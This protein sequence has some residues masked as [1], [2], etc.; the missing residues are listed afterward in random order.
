MFKTKTT[1]MKFTMQFALWVG[2][3]TKMT[4]FI[5]E[6]NKLNKKIKNDYKIKD[7]YGRNLG[8]KMFKKYIF[9]VDDKDYTVIVKLQEGFT[10]YGGFIEALQ[11]KITYAQLEEY[12][13]ENKKRRK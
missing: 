1:K 6:L 13:C 2:I 3:G 9:E 8:Y 4:E 5:K 11:D 10:N 7:I 12:T